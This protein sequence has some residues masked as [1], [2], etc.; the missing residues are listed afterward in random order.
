MDFKFN[1]HLTDADYL[2]YNV[3]WAIKSPYGKKQMRTFRILI[4]AAILL[5]SLFI[6][7]RDRFSS[8]A[9]F[10]A[11]A[12]W[13]LLA[14]IEAFLTPFYVWI[15]KNQI[16]SL[17]KHGK[18]GYSPDS[19]MEFFEDR[20]TETTPENKTEQKYSA[21]ERISVIGGKYVYIHVNNLMA[22]ILPMSCFASSEEFERFMRFMCAKCGKIDTY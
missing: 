8:D 16:K 17:K 5:F 4:A 2:D 21:V 7:V 22:Y 3:F 12:Q 18:M 19:E 15:L 9:F 14:I 11:S 6:L 20:F 10:S 13:F 1:V